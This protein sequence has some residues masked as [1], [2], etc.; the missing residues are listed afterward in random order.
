MVH[1]RNLAPV[2]NFRSLTP[3]SFAMPPADNSDGHH[4]SDVSL[5]SGL[6]FDLHSGISSIHE[7]GTDE[8]LKTQ[9]GE[10]QINN[11]IKIIQQTDLKVS[12]KTALPV[13]LTDLNQTLNSIPAK[14]IANPVSAELT[15]DK[16]ITP[17]TYNHNDRFSWEIYIT[18][19]F[20]T[21]YLTGLNYQTIAQTIQ[22]APIMV[23]HIANVNGFVDNTPVRWVTMLVEIFLYRISKNISLKA[24]LEFSF[25]RYYIKAYNSDPSQASATL[26]SYFGYIAADSLNNSSGGNFDRQKSTTLSEPVLSA[27]H[28]YRRRNESSR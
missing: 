27:F 11:H 13:A 17:L 23:V 2:N 3:N 7:S 25:N 24:G 6:P 28:S 14:P 26:N 5:N 9:T 21:H 19:T 1:L 4:G 20:N 8:K 16:S 15:P 12:A 22:T 18:P 10:I